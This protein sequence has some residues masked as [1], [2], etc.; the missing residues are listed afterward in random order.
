MNYQ[1]A[2][3]IQ[4]VNTSFLTRRNFGYNQRPQL[5]NNY[6]V[7]AQIEPEWIV[8]NGYA[9]EREESGKYKIRGLANEIF[10]RQVK[11]AD[12]TERGTSVTEE[13]TSVP[14][15]KD[16]KSS[17]KGKSTI[18]TGAKYLKHSSADRTPNE[19]KLQSKESTTS[20]R[21]IV[22]SEQK[23]RKLPI[24]K[25]PGTS[26][27]RTTGNIS[28]KGSEETESSYSTDRKTSESISHD[29]SKNDSTST[30][31]ESY[32]TKSDSPSSAT[33]KET[34]DVE[35]SNSQSTVDKV[36]K[37]SKKS[38]FRNELKGHSSSVMSSESLNETDENETFSLSE[39]KSTGRGSGRAKV[40][41]YI[42]VDQSSSKEYFSEKKPYRI[43]LGER[44]DVS[45]PKIMPPTVKCKGERK[46]VPKHFR[47]T[48][49]IDKESS[50][51]NFSHSKVRKGSIRSQ[52]SG[53]CSLSSTNSFI[54]TF[55]VSRQ[56]TTDRTN[57]S[58]RYMS[59]NDTES[60]L[61]HVKSTRKVLSN[62][63][64]SHE[65]RSFHFPSLRYKESFYPNV[66]GELD[67]PN[68]FL[69]GKCTYTW[70]NKTFTPMPHHPNCCKINTNCEKLNKS[71]DIDDP[72]SLQLNSSKIECHSNITES[73][74]SAL[75][76]VDDNTSDDKAN[77]DK[78]D[79]DCTVPSSDNELELETD[80]EAATSHDTD[81]RKKLI[82]KRLMETEVNEISILSDTSKEEQAKYIK[83]SY[84]RS[85]C[86]SRRLKK[87]TE[88]IFG[89]L[90]IKR[91]IDK[92]F[93]E[94]NE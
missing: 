18:K 40:N 78:D 6:I 66:I 35:S 31:E 38:H 87:R 71:S 57:S 42:I 24:K 17:Q 28:T 27:M 62:I 37:S 82:D 49:I 43:R 72:A 69:N 30:S 20:D 21:K 15:Y 75:S 2:K 68:M 13:E 39:E 46:K 59:K 29:S 8:Q 67:D 41:G 1:K 5:G 19:Y 12:G 81:C 14:N 50:T 9:F 65:T 33:S 26:A 10:D 52:S 60:S 77:R 76:I 23:S 91:L 16:I 51:A 63:D 7:G 84:I 48:N 34:C 3:Y 53:S 88:K 73:S 25:K 90:N 80:G 55:W 86:F 74:I 64:C 94:K 70:A 47:K 45:R 92:L 89:N 22:R 56:E 79:K 93:K 36:V 54:E 61:D 11:I 4:G 83:K 85:K 32:E 44:G 58:V